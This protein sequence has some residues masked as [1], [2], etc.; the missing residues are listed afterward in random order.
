MGASGAAHQQPSTPS[1]SLLS[2]TVPSPFRSATPAAASATSSS[3][4]NTSGNAAIGQAEVVA[5]ATSLNILLKLVHF[6]DLGPDRSSD[7]LD[8]CTTSHLPSLL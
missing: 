6:F 1:R 2:L 7:A 5:A 3:S 8:V 4:V